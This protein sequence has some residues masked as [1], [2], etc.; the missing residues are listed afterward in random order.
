LSSTTDNPPEPAQ[1]NGNNNGKRTNVNPSESE[2]P[3]KKHRVAHNISQHNGLTVPQ[4]PQFATSLYVLLSF[5]CLLYVLTHLYRR[6]R[7]TITESVDDMQQRYM[8][9]MLV[10]QAK[11]RRLNSFYRK[12]VYLFI[13]F[14]THSFHLVP[15]F[16]TSSSSYHLLFSRF[17]IVGVVWNCWIFT[18]KK[19]EAPHRARGSS[20]SYRRK[21]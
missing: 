16:P 2:R 8:A 3:T 17:L 4:S 7:R 18:Y 14:F 21:T 15:Q 1:P 12:K 9:A 20:L 19:H 10:A 6:V 11:R 5:K 13:C